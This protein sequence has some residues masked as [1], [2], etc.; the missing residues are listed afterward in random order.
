MASGLLV[1]DAVL[2]DPGTEPRRADCRLRDGQVLETGGLVPL[3]GEQVLDAGGK[4]LVPAI[5]DLHIHLRVPGQEESEDLESGCAALWHGGTAA[6]VA[7]PNTDPPLEE[8]A[9]LQGQR[10]AAAALGI[11]L[12]PATAATADRAGLLPSPHLRENAQAGFVIATDDGASVPTTGVLRDTLAALAEA[13]GVHLCH[14]EEPTLS[15]GK[16]L[17]L[18]DPDRGA[19]GERGHPRMA[20]DVLVARDI[21]MGMGM[22]ART[23][24]THLSSQVSVALVRALKPLSGGLVTADTTYHHLLVGE[25]EV[26]ADPVRWKV[27]PPIRE[28][29]DQDALRAAVLDGTMDALVTDHAPHGTRKEGAALAD[30][31][32][33]LSSA[34]LTLSLLTTL[35]R[36]LGVGL[37][38]LLPLATSG[39]AAILGLAGRGR[40]APGQAADLLLVDPEEEWVPGP[41]DILSKGKNS[42]WL[43]RR[44][45][46]RITQR[47]RAGVVVGR[48]GR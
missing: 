19:D 30:A 34:D 43:G 10:E 15:R 28:Q 2:C 41:D 35:A 38:R 46:G 4:W 45:T 42:P 7:M 47:L 40:L 29:S 9:L 24:L 32:F 31:P 26:A 37:E 12:W 18:P 11:D 13:G 3:V 17:H 25:E 48:D 39:P 8:P 1:R 27:N 20:E 6:A 36:E 33:G 21:V 16:S 5:V 22:G 23:H 14:S 44:L